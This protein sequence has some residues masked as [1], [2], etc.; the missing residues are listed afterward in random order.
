MVMKVVRISEGAKELLK[1]VRE[2]NFSRSRG[3]DYVNNL[4]LE[5][6]AVMGRKIKRLSSIKL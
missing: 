2:L 6:E 5:A 1:V 4:F 3:T